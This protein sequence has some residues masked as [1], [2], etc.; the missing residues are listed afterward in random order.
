MSDDPPTVD[1]QNDVN[2]AVAQPTSLVET[3]L[4]AVRRD[5]LSQRV[6]DGSLRGSTPAR[7]LEQDRLMRAEVAEAK[8][9]PGRPHV[10]PPD[11]RRPG[12]HEPGS[13]SRVET[14]RERAPVERVEPC[15]PPAPAGDEDHHAEGGEPRRLVDEQRD[16]QERGAEQ[17]GNRRRDANGVC[18]GQAEA[19]SGREKLR[20]TGAR[21]PGQGATRSRSCSIRA[22][23]MPGTASS[24]STDPKA[25]CFRR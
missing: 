10:E 8:H 23:P 2:A 24:S 4:W 19:E 13:G 14:A 7:E 20:R 16:E 21:G 15:A 6:D 18:T 5:E 12:D 1:S 11:P 17:L 25:P 9:E 22:G 3:V